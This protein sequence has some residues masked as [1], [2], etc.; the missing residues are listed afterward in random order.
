M[1]ARARAAAA[2]A[3]RLGRQGEWFHSLE[4]KQKIILKFGEY[5]GA[6]AQLGWLSEKAPAEAFRLQHL[7]GLAR[8]RAAAATAARLGRQGEWF[9]SLERKQKII[10][11]FEEYFGAVAQLG[12]RMVRNH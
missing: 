2:T 4:Q 12:E 10:L 9:H 7:G 5:F 11:K 1:S 6:V 3:A 8:A